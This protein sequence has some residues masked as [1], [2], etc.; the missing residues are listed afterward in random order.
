MDHSVMPVA[1]I[2]AVLVI[3]TALME[4]RQPGSARRE[5]AFV[6]N[7]PSLAAGL[8]AALLLGALG[9]PSMRYA[10]VA[11]SMLAGVL[12]A[13]LIAREPPRR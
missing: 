2:A 13:Y 6:S 3:R 11:W 9:W 8:L 5:W 10:A 12:V 7:G 1:I 4:L